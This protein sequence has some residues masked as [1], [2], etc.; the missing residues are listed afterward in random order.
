LVD[1]PK[2]G[3]GGALVFVALSVICR[4]D[5]PGS[6]ADSSTCRPPPRPHAKGGT[7]VLK[8]FGLLLGILSLVWVFV[9]IG[10]GLLIR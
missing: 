8:R 7:M 1:P 9:Q 10:Y 6:F 5:S 3:A 2:A 4:T